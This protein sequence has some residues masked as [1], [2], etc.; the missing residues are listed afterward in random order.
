[1][2]PAAEAHSSDLMEV[3]AARR[4]QARMRAG[5]AVGLTLGFGTITGWPWAL[6]WLALYGGL[7]AVEYFLL[8]RRTTPSWAALTLLA[9]NGVVFG[10]F[11][12][13]GPL[14]D[15]VFGLACWI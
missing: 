7:Q 3:I 14:R 5:L 1:M 4:S 15:G 13:A 2:S 10:A 12:A 9:T 8:G 6:V 11:A